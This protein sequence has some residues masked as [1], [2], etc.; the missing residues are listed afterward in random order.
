MA[1]SE[2][3][4]KSCFKCNEE[5]DLQDFYKKPNSKD[6]TF[7]VCK[8]CY[9]ERE[10]LKNR[11]K[12]GFSSLKTDYCECCGEANVK[13]QLDHCHETGMFRGFVCRP[14]N[15]TIGFNGDTYVSL[16]AAGAN[17]IYLDY[18]KLANYRMGKL[19]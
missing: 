14:C 9:S 10:N 3:N 1:L 8:P 15:N 6:G 11:L 12:A 16:E 18:M 13:I 17:K 2:N 19:V 4:M 5:K 7:N